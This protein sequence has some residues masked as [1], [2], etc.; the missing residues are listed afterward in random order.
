MLTYAQHNK[1]TR[2]SWAS[3][4]PP[5]AHKEPYRDRLSSFDPSGKPYCR[6]LT[7]AA[8]AQIRSRR[9]WPGGSRPR[10]LLASSTLTQP[11]KPDRTNVAQKLG[12]RRPPVRDH[13]LSDR[14]GVCR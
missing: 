14:P 5:T 2:W 9:G 10:R 6:I 8:S 1:M 11:S 12:Y 4:S 13:R 3:T 7:L